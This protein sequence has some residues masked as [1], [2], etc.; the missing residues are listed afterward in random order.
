MQ[1]SRSFLNNLLLFV[2]FFTIFG[3]IGREMLS[4]VAPP[5]QNATPL[6]R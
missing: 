4:Y 5:P 6:R 1:L 2:F 3:A